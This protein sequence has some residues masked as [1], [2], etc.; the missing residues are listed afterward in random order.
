M[1]IVYFKQIIV[2]QTFQFLCPLHM[3]ISWHQSC[4]EEYQVGFK[5]N[6]NMVEINF[7]IIRLCSNCKFASKNSNWINMKMRQ[8]VN[9]HGSPNYYV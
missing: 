5:D 6:I 4:S 8:R 2:K 7:Q 3:T 1:C 9:G